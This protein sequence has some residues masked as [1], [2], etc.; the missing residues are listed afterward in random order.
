MTKGSSRSLRTRENDA[1]WELPG[2]VEFGEH[3]GRGV[4][5]L[6]VHTS[7]AATRRRVTL[8]RPG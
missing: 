2:Y 7:N 6:V 5:E 4:G 3:R 8:D 1:P